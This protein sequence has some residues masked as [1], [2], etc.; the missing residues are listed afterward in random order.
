MLSRSPTEAIDFANYQAATTPDTASAQTVVDAINAAKEQVRKN[1]ERHE[2]EKASAETAKAEG[3]G[4]FDSGP[5][6]DPNS[7]FLQH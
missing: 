3:I 4:R 6:V 2:R 7:P 1:Q 5:A